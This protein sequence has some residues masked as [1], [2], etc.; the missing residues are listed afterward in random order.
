MFS[1]NK[2]TGALP[3]ISN[4]M[5]DYYDH[6]WTISPRDRGDR[7]MERAEKIVSMIPEG[8]RSVLEVGCGDGLIINRIAVEERMGTDLSKEGLK[9]VNCPTVICPAHDMPFPDRRWDVVIASEVLEHIPEDEYEKSLCEIARIANNCILIS[10]PNREN[11]K[12]AQTKCPCCGSVYHPFRHLRSFEPVDLEKLFPG[13]RIH[14]VL[15]IGHKYRVMTSPEIF[16][17][18]RILR[19]WV[20]CAGGKCPVCGLLRPGESLAEVKKGERGEK[21]AG[22]KRGMFRLTDSVFGLRRRKRWICA[23]FTR[24]KSPN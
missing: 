24:E 13:F 7:D 19:R 17:R 2:P 10:V 23:L 4:N 12:Q 21:L 18:Y 6:C 9:S 15:E 20:H 3:S 11:L 1:E 22:L 16:I 8:A 14:K 5:K